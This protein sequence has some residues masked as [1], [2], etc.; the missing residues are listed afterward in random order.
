[1]YM[2]FVCMCGAASEK[3]LRENKTKKKRHKT[4]NANHIQRPKGQHLIGKDDTL[5]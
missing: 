5:F 4:A 3:G 2:L 1:M